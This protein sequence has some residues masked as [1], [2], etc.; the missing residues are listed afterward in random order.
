MK[1]SFI[2]QMEAMKLFIINV[3][4]ADLLF[5]SQDIDL[6]IKTSLFQHSQDRN[7]FWIS[8]P[9]DDEDWGDEG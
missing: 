2:N 9:K 7:S 6:L 8:D 5:F 1:F 4:K 3:G